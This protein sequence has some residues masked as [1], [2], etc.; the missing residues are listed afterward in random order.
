MRV[1]WGPWLLWLVGGFLFLLGLG[2]LVEEVL[3]RFLVVTPVAAL[4]AFV[5][6]LTWP[7]P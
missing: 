3:T 6:Y 2:G 1:G 7:E 5:L 4:L